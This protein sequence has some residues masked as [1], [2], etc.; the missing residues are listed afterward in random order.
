MTALGG[1]RL[2]R[3]MKEPAGLLEAFCLGLGGDY[4]GVYM[5]E[6]TELSF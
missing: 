6:S 1:N 2:G 5:Y 4:T 3:G